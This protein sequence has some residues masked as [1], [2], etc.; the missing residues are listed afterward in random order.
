MRPIQSITKELVFSFL[1]PRAPESHKGNYG[2]VLAVC[3]C[4]E[5][6][7]AAALACLGALRAG[8]GLVTLAAPE[9]VCTCVAPRILEATFLCAQSREELLS[10]AAQYTVCLAGCGRKPDNETANEMS[11]LLAAAKGCFVLDAGGLSAI[12]TNHNALRPCAGRLVVTP[13]PGEM[14]RLAGIPVAQVLQMPADVALGFSQKTGAI[15][16]LKGH[17]TLVATPDG[18]LYRNTTG[19]AGLARGGSGDILAGIIAGLAAQGLSPQ[20]AALCGVWLH[21]AAA[22]KCAAQRSMQ[23]MLP[24]DILEALCTV[25]LENGR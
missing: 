11:A 20:A 13:H 17:R 19:N 8:A 22:D 5:Y 15:T 6:R 1:A 14:A 10:A 18:T 3:G 4:E 21:G 9:C 24:E 12:G 16:V 7:G 23:G 2:K 25:F